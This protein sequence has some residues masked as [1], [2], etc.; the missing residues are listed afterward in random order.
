MSSQTT[1]PTLHHLSTSGAQR[2]LW[3]LEELAHAHGLVYHLVAYARV[4]GLAPPEL[5]NIFPLGASPIVVIADGLVPDAATAAAS[6]SPTVYQILPGVL[7]E[8]RAILEFFDR[9]YALGLWTPDG[10]E[11]ARRD[12]F[13]TE[14]S[15]AT[16]QM[17]VNQPMIFDLLG[18]MAPWF[19]RP[20]VRAINDPIAGFFRKRLRKSFS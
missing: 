17:A 5:K 3:A 12:V 7:T 16:L 19:V 2:V 9:E 14:F 8:A 18:Q 20:L 11:D 13:W 15:V 6:P 10:F 1:T 4:R